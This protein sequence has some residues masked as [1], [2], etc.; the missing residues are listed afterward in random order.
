MTPPTP[1]PSLIIFTLFFHHFQLWDQRGQYY[2]D[3]EC[4][5]GTAFIGESWPLHL[6]PT[7]CIPTKTLIPDINRTEKQV[8]LMNTIHSYLADIDHCSDLLLHIFPTT[9]HDLI[10]LILHL[11]DHWALVILSMN[12]PCRVVW[13][14]AEILIWRV[15]RI[16]LSPKLS[17]TF[18]SRKD[19]SPSRSIPILRNSQSSFTLRLYAWVVI[20]ILEDLR[21]PMKLETKMND[22]A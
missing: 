10:S 8:H 12:R 21:V 5:S 9:S 17:N 19:L 11:C 14:A 18:F 6:C 16:V 22:H 1:K 4:F 3:F 2:W 20:I 15:G 7:L 13:V